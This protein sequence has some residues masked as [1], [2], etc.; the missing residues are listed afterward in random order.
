M[1]RSSLHSLGYFNFEDDRCPLLA[2][3]CP[4]RVSHGRF[5]RV[6]VCLR[7]PEMLHYLQSCFW[8]EKG[9]QM[10][11]GGEATVLKGSCATMQT[12]LVSGVTMALLISMLEVGVAAGRPIF[13]RFET[14]KVGTHL[15]TKP[16][17]HSDDRQSLW[18]FIQRKLLTWAK[19]TWDFGKTSG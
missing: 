19:A 7:T 2:L 6:C 10:G 5:A 1:T 17:C 16:R 15:Q 3:L 12:V 4:R 13:T 18:L 11:P 14:K 9:L 8:Q